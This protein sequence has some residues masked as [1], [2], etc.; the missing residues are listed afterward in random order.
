MTEKI[1][2][3]DDDL[4][5]L[6][7]IGLLLQRQGYQVVAAPGGAEGLAHAKSEIPDLILLDIMMPNMDGYEVCRRL[8]ADPQLAHI[9]VI[10]FTAKTRVDDKVA[11]F[12]AGAD[13]YLTK[14]THPA[15]LASRIRTLLTRSA[16][17]RSVVIE[18]AQGKVIAILGVKGGTGVTTLA[19]NLCATLVQPDRK[20]ILA[21]LH[22]GMGAIGLQ[23]G[24][25]QE[26]GLARIF[27]LRLSELGQE[28]I[29]AE[30]IEYSPGMRLLLSEYNPSEATATFPVG[31]V[32]RIVAILPKMADMVILDLGNGIGNASL[33]ALKQADQIILCLPPRRTSIAMAMT[34]VQQMKTSGIRSD[35]VSVAVVNTAPMAPAASLEQLE[36][37][38]QLP[39]VGTIEFA[40]ELVVSALEQGKPMVQVQ[41]T[42]PIAHR[43]QELGER[44]M[45]GLNKDSDSGE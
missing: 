23:L 7:L 20:L 24:F 26:D 28:Q 29:E 18:H 25:A 21:D 5:S 27:K 16:T 11:G 43:F 32:E 22:P 36:A 35:R 6:K 39:I 33:Q 1:L 44:V 14:P 8:R 45:A 4:D 3:I 10:M 13:D 15:E 17:I 30:L 31:H 19:I 34:L 2:V 42:S 12:E 37:Q 9:P 38:L 41:P 40:P